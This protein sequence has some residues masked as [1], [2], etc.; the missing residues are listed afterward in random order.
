[1]EEN[2]IFSRKIK[3]A[4]THLDVPLLDEFAFGVLDLLL[5]PAEPDRSKFGHF[6][7]FLK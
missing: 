6:V 4:M 7:V 5:P 1:M 3:T 2:C